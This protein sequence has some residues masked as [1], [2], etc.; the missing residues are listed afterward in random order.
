MRNSLNFDFR[1]KK[2]LSDTRFSSRISDIICC[3]SDCF[4]KNGDYIEFVDSTTISYIPKSKIDVFNKNPDRNKYEVKIKVGRFISRFMRP[5][6]LKEYTHPSD[7][8]QFVNE[9]KSYFDCDESKLKIV[10]G[11]D[12][13]KYYHEENYLC[14]G[15]GGTLWKSCMRQSNRNKFMKLYESNDVQMLVF[16]TDND[17]VR[18]R[19]L[20]WKAIDDN[21]NIYNIM[22]RIYIIYDH[23]TNFFINWAQRNGF[24]T[25]WEQTA[26]NESTFRDSNGNPIILELKIVLSKKDFTYYPYLDTFKFFDINNGILYNK[27][28]NKSQYVLVQSDGS[29]EKEEGDDETD[30]EF[31]DLD[32]SDDF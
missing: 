9:Y 12:I 16:L 26:Y 15:N 5:E 6:V 23:D 1:L 4:K 19:A 10:S 30:D 11:S 20:L 7:I 29:I 17:K 13:L 14:S 25:K 3:I 22:D 28:S 32:I 21:G 2:F 18:A 27:L 8:E 31:V 24:Y